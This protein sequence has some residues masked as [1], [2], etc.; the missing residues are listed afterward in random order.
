[1]C[2]SCAEVDIF[3]MRKAVTGP[4]LTHSQEEHVVA[5]LKGR[6]GSGEGIGKRE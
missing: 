3:A 2:G 5:K 6:S 1:M 4:T